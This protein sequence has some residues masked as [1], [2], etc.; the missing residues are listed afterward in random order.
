MNYAMGGTILRKTVKEQYSVVSRNANTK[1]SL[2]N[3]ELQRL[4]A[5]RF[6][7]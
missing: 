5:N 7:E 1:V 4:R 3:A 2:N 6:L